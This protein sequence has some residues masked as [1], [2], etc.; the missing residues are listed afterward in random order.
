MILDTWKRAKRGSSEGVELMPPAGF[1]NYS[2]A[3]SAT[4]V[5]V[6]ISM[7]ARRSTYIYCLLV[8]FPISLPVFSRVIRVSSVAPIV[9]GIKCLADDPFLRIAR[10]TNDGR[11]VEVERAIIACQRLII[12]IFFFAEDGRMYHDI[13][14]FNLLK[15]KRHPLG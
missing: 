13:G 5:F 14:R 15:R 8:P 3:A 6:F 4:V 10:T 12:I 9:R 2:S 7:S 1:Q 11:E